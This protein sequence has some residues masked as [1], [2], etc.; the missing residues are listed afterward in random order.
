MGVKHYNPK[1]IVV[2]FGPTIVEGI[3][4][5]TFVEV[6]DNEDAA[7]LYVGGDGKGTRAM[8]N[9]RSAKIKITLSQASKTNEL[10]SLMLELDRTTGAGVQPLSIKDLNGTSLHTAATT[11]IKKRPTTSY[12]KKIETRVWELE[13][14]YMVPFDGS[15]GDPP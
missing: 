14:D 13:T 1:D 10:F 6:E 8:S 11:W 5:G 9:N 7:S 2:V 4:D 15:A 3:A 12:S